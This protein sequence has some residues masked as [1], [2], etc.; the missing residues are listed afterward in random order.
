MNIH[1]SKRFS[2]KTCTE[3]VLTISNATIPPGVCLL[4]KLCDFG[5]FLLPKNKLWEG[6]RF[7]TKNT[8]VDSPFHHHHRCHHRYIQVIHSPH[9]IAPPTCG[10]ERVCPGVTEAA[11]AS[12][13][14]IWIISPQIGVKIKHV[15]NHHLGM[16]WKDPS[17][18]DTL[19]IGFNDNL[20]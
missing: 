20:I 6:G 1:S 3:C 11:C 2:P 13:K 4:K 5:H 15:W 12:V 9:L 18:W 8:Q 10:P 7:Q 16:L 17:F 14:S 19:R